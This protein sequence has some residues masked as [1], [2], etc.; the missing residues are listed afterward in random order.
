MSDGRKSADHSRPA[1]DGCA[2]PAD[3]YDAFASDLLAALPL[4]AAPTHRAT[5]LAAGGD[6]A[7][8]AL[9][10]L[11]ETSLLEASGPPT[12]DARRYGLHTV[13]RSFVSAHLPLAT[14]PQRQALARLGQHYAELAETWG[15]A[16]PN[17]RSFGRLE[18]ELSNIMAVVES[19]ST[20]ARERDADDH[21]Q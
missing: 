18:R 16:A 7:E 1:S 10:E 6:A 15:G 2:A 5:L 20:Q 9:D 13:T 3:S 8:V 17:W 19:G 14:Q 11:L 12:D 21:L 4:L